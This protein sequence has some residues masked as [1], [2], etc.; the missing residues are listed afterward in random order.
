MS[1]KHNGV[2]KIIDCVGTFKVEKTNLS[3]GDGYPDIR[4]SFS[5]KLFH[6]RQPNEG[7]FSIPFGA[8]HD[9]LV[10]ALTKDGQSLQNNGKKY[11]AVLLFIEVD[12]EQS[13]FTEPIQLQL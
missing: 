13:A 3:K 6:E 11:R 1:N 10:K 12:E 2:H 9:K 8:P 5:S 4:I 7:G